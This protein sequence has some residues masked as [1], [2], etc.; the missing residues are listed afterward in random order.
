MGTIAVRHGRDAIGSTVVQA[1]TR[2]EDACAFC[3]ISLTRESGATMPRKTPGQLADV[4]RAALPEGFEHVVLTTGTTGSEDAGIGYLE[5]CAR[6][7]KSATGGGM[8]VH[9]QFEPPERLEWIESIAAFAD[10]AAVN[11]ECFDP[12]TLARV[13]PAKA[14]AGIECYKRTWRR[15]VDAFGPGQVACFIIAGL[16]ERPETVI[17]GCRLL[18][19]LGV[20]PFVL[21]LRPISGTALGGSAPPGAREMTELYEQASAVIKESGMRAGDC[22]AGC[23]RCGACSAIGDF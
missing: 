14:S 18:C 9:V 8:K 21:P 12:D 2:G 16:G 20:F 13:A 10:S 23:V 22:S 5:E 17:E 7:V 6:A 15:A 1:C 19:S 11:M 4:A 3:G